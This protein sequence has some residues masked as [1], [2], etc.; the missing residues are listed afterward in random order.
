MI[1]N[2]EATEFDLSLYDLFRI[3]DVNGDGLMRDSIRDI[4]ID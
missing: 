1:L 2:E 4:L 3:W